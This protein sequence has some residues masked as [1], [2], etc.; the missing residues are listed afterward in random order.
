MNAYANHP[1]WRVPREDRCQAT[2]KPAEKTDWR[3]WN[4]LPRR[5]QR[6]AEQCRDGVPVCWQH[7]AA[8]TLTIWTERDE[9]QLPSF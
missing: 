4:K 1:T 2:S 5:C 7:A 8:E 9:E 6:P 3:W